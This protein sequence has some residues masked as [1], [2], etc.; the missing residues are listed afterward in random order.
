MSDLPGVP[1]EMQGVIPY[2]VVPDAVKAMEF[3]E[4][5]L[6]AQP[7]MR[8]PGPGGQG[9]MHAEMKIGNGTIM[10]TDEN[11]QWGMKSPATFGGSP[12]SL[13]IYVENVDAVFDQAVAAGCQAKFP[14]DDMFWGDRMGK[15]TDPFGYD[16]SVTTHVE[17]LSEEEMAKRQ[18]EWM[19]Q[20]AQT[21]DP[22]Q[23]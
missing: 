2:L 14:V 9:T 4:K 3:Y 10:L 11:P 13:M 17:D 1:P 19:A 5:A 21:P 8:M 6:G 15:L 16:W 23:E 20:M 12:V 7:V 22:G 18:Q